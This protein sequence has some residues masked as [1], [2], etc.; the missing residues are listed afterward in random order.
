VLHGDISPRYQRHGKKILVGTY[1]N[2]IK[3][4]NNKNVMVIIIN[5]GI[6]EHISNNE[7]MRY[8]CPLQSTYGPSSRVYVVWYGR[9]VWDST[10]RATEVRRL[11]TA[12]WPMR[13][14]CPGPV[15]P[16]RT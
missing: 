9:S 13:G 1:L 4:E 5:V 10:L 3:N 15:V 7:I 6:E 16:Y 8:L 11:K 2:N 12:L 14:W